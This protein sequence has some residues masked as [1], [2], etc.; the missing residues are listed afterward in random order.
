MDNSTQV[1]SKESKISI[2]NSRVCDTQAAVRD[3][4]AKLFETI[5]GMVGDSDRKE[6]SLETTAPVPSGYINQIIQNAEVIT[7]MVSE[8][9]L[10]LDRL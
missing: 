7:S 3:L 9:M 2:A 8:M 6:P 4:K 5:N 10:A 1:G